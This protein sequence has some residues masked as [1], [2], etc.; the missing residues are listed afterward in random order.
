M[1]QMEMKE[2][3]ASM[4]SDFKDNLSG[5]LSHGTIISS[6]EIEEQEKIPPAL[7]LMMA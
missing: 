2:R 3:Q 4:M 7:Q 6:A 1:F 5:Y